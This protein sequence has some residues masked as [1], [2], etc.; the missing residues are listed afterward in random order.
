MYTY[1][2][3]CVMDLSDNYTLLYSF[4]GRALLD[5]FGV[6]GER[7]LREGT[8]RYGR[9]RGAHSRQR[10]L[11][12]GVKINM[13]SLFSVGGDLPPDPRFKR[14]L[15]ELN[16]EERVSHTLVCPMADVWKAYGARAIGRMYCEEFHPACYNHYAY[17]YGHTN[18]S[19]T[20]TQE[21]DEYCAFNVVLRAENLPDSLK[22]KCFAQYDPGYVAPAV[23]PKKA[24]GKLG[25][26]TLSIK[27][28]YYILEAA[29]EQ[30]G[31][32]GADAIDRGLAQMAADGASR[33]K[34]T[35]N[36]YQLSDLAQV[37]YDTYPLSVTPSPLWADYS[38][39]DARAR[40]TR[41][42]VPAFQAAL[43]AEVK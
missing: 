42:F 39:H 40:F 32:P 37:A 24:C 14:E 12:L 20:L 15:Q 33:A 9:D 6:E 29:L 16:P 11:E 1:E 18:L 36:A 10:H 23:T 5:A 35:A 13:Q 7:A 2:E 31:E 8:R 22:P 43:Q 3:Q 4:I 27:L 30:L 34:A 17:D 21:T 41:V 28:Y 38:S 26:E 25:F 19:K